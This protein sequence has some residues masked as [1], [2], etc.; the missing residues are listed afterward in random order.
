VAER[1]EE[2]KQKHPM[3][4]VPPLPPSPPRPE[5]TNPTRNVFYVDLWPDD[6]PHPRDIEKYNQA[7]DAFYE[8][9]EEYLIERDKAQELNARKLRLK[10]QL[11]N[12]GTAPVEKAAIFMKIPR[13]LRLT[14]NEQ[15]FKYP[16]TPALPALP[17]PRGYS[18]L[19]DIYQ[20]P[21][22]ADIFP[23]SR[24]NTYVEPPN[25]ER[26]DF[27]QDENYHRVSF[28]VRQAT[29]NL[30]YDCPYDLFIIFDS[31]ET[32]LSF[33]IDYQ[34]IAAN[35][36]KPVDGQLHV[37]IKRNAPEVETGTPLEASEGE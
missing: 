25:V 19:R 3:W 18:A 33:H 13:H 5:N 31:L 20:P 12:E 37:I 24:L 32:A 6:K 36:P 1:L 23:R 17:E 29:H 15:V 26:N 34:I 30:V 28:R 16:K 4:D 27:S 9:Y 10:I 21:R 7:L 14:Q 11:V 2:I 8:E 35:V 22:F